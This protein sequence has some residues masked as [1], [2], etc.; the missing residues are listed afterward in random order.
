MTDRASSADPSQAVTAAVLLLGGMTIMANATLSPSLP[1]LRAHFADVPAIDT[2][3]GLVVTLPSLAVVL[4]AGAFGWLTDRVDRQALL[5]LSGF[6][7]AVGGTSGLWVQNL[8]GILIGRLVLGIGVAGAMVLATTW[9]A[10]LW[11]GEARTRF[12]GLQGAFMSAGGIVVILIGGTLSSL[13]WRGAFATY[14]LVVPITVFALAALRPHARERRHRQSARTADQAS[15]AFPWTVFAF[16][17]AQAM[18]FMIA[19][20]VIPTRL[21]FLLREVG[22]S[23]PVALSVI[24]ALVTLAA[25][26]G[27]LAYGRLRRRL[28]TLSVFVLCWSM[29]GLG[30]LVLSMATNLAVMVLGVVLVGMGLGPAM[31]NQTAHLMA[32]M[33][34]TQRGRA[35]GLLTTAVFAGQFVSPL[36]SGPL[37]ERLG[38]DGALRVFGIVQIALALGLATIVMY[39]ARYPV[40]A[41]RV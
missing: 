34:P 20:Y 40:M 28:S 25:L 18:L 13:H 19:F 32:A 5:L 38:E 41:D 21:P 33:P 37:V 14:L 39:R 36:F 26:P 2:L 17:G 30:L 11:Q 16:V 15:H 22:V 8:F 31:P 24:V 9:A 12:L 10:D 27:A 35:S 23:N 4:T 1:A 6:L 3:A 7:Y 29:M